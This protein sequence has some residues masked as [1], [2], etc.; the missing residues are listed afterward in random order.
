MSQPVL[1]SHQLMSQYCKCNL[2]GICLDGLVVEGHILKCNEADCHIWKYAQQHVVEAQ[3]KPTHNTGS[4]KL[5]TLVEVQ[6]YVEMHHPWA[7]VVEEREGD[8]IELVYDFICRQ[9]LASA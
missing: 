6:N 7:P 1:I 8:L 5:P 9:L 3:P 4:P 2:R